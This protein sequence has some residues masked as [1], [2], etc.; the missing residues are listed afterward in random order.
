MGNVR[1]QTIK[2]KKFDLGGNY[3]I[4]TALHFPGNC[5]EAHEL[6]K[7]AFGMTIN[8]VAYNHEAPSDSHDTPLTEENKNFIMHSECSIYGIRINMN[9]VPNTAIP[10]NMFHLNIFL[11]SEEDV[12]RAFD[13][14]KQNGV[15]F[16]EPQPVFW[17]SLHCGLKDRF[18]ITWQIMTE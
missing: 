3:V 15:V 13:V 17:S 8:S 2:Q 11:S 7:Q 6:Y 1:G 4:V 9:D 18:G 10:G 14:L 16:S 5:A 12:L